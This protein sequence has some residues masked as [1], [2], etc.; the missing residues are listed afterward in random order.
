MLG[1]V[2]TIKVVLYYIE[3]RFFIKLWKTLITN[4]GRYTNFSHN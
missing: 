1:Y 4:Y 2:K 3:V